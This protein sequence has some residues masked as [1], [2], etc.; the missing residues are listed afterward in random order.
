VSEALTGMV[1]CRPLMSLPVSI[2]V[3]VI[4]VFGATLLLTVA[5]TCTLPFA[6]GA[7]GPVM[8]KTT[9]FPI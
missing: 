3:F 5:P 9:V 1:G 6:P 4:V 7:S 2:T 8:V